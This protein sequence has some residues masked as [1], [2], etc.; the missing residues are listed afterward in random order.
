MRTS[1]TLLGFPY[2]LAAA[3][4]AVP[5]SANNDFTVSLDGS[6]ITSIT[7]G[8][9]VIPASHMAN[10]YSSGG[11]DFLG[12]GTGPVQAADDLDLATYFARN[13]GSAPDW[14][15]NFG[16]HYLPSSTTPDFV[17]FEAG[18]NDTLQAQPI[19]IDGSEGVPVVL[20]GNW[21]NTGY[22][23]PTGPN[24]GQ[25]VKGLAFRVTDLKD[26]AGAPLTL[27]QPLAGVKL[28][29]PSVDGAAFIAL[30]QDFVGDNLPRPV[31]TANPPSIPRGDGNQTVVELRAT[32]YD[33]GTPPATDYS[34]DWVVPGGTFVGGTGPNDPVIQ[35][36]FAG[37]VPGKRSFG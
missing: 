12:Q 34:L 37:D 26:A 35:V 28:L 5:T 33:A 8:G 25:P 1:P 24:A 14:R 10:G 22:L 19:L 11:T 15:I 6:K 17:V 20:S 27:T 30:R 2:I 32:P 21:C 4:L 29:S 23:S 36:T 13:F 18:G 3:T 7:F 9:T 16:M 31:I